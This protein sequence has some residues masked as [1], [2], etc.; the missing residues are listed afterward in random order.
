MFNS[1]VVTLDF[2]YNPALSD[3]GHNDIGIGIR[4]E[5]AFFLSFG[6]ISVMPVSSSAPSC[7][8]GSIL[9]ARASVS[10]LASFHELFRNPWSIHA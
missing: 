8:S 2:A 9:P 7:S 3:V 4:I 6:V 1:L 5:I 10:K